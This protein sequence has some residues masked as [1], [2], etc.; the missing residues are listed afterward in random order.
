MCGGG[1][2]ATFCRCRL[3]DFSACAARMTTHLATDLSFHERTLVLSTSYLPLKAHGPILYLPPNVSTHQVLSA[4]RALNFLLS[5]LT[6]S[7]WEKN[8][9]EYHEWHLIIQPSQARA[10]NLFGKKIREYKNPVKMNA[11]F[12]VYVHVCIFLE[13]QF[14]AANEVIKELVMGSSVQS[15]WVLPHSITL[16]PWASS[17]PFIFLICNV[18][19]ITVF[20]PGVV[21][22][23][24]QDNLKYL[25]KALQT[26]PG[27]GRCPVHIFHY[28]S[29]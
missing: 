20:M 4:T 28:S 19:V 14:D 22:Q 29:Y 12:C 1:H 18:G 26:M 8:C 27:H 15:A 16:W 13:R 7:R 9:P 25:S 17:L 6:K 11:D 24:K 5:I 2:W 3:T 10:L 23:S 21:M